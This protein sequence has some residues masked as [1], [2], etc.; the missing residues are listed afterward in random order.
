[1]LKISRRS[2]LIGASLLVTTRGQA[3]A[4]NGAGLSF[5]VVGDWGTGSPDQRKVAVQMAMVAKATD[6]RFVISTGDNFYP[7]GV[8]S[9][10][11]P[12]WQTSFENIYR[13]PELQIPWYAVLGN[14]DHHDSVSAQI[15]YSEVSRRWNMPATFYK[16]AVELTGESTADLFF[17][18][19]QPIK[20]RYSSW[21][22]RF[23]E[24]EQLAWLER[25]LADSKAQWKIV[26]GHHPVYS[27]GKHGTEAM[28]DALKPLLDRYGVQVYLNGHNHTLEHV[29]AGNTHYLT[30]GA[31]ST[32]RPVSP[33]S[34]TQYALGSRLGFMA[35]Q[36]EPGAMRFTFYDDQG[37][38][39]YNAEIPSRV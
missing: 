29:I 25:E 13:E 28:V 11:D 19:T 10:D 7:D 36:L 3:F 37:Q 24:N 15:G 31:G 30:C 32:P 35:A 38:T 5:L 8:S 22:R 17:L 27:G 14:H 20:K 9:V 6:A 2:F 26:V 1:M 4:A 34:G 23:F 39:L 33:V 12:Q 18:D 16:V 21:I